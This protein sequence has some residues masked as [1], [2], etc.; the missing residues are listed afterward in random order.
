MG[1]SL[2]EVHNTRFGSLPGNIS[3]K[4]VRFLGRIS[5]DLQVDPLRF[6]PPKI[7]RMAEITR[8]SRESCDLMTEWSCKGEGEFNVCGRCQPCVLNDRLNQFTRWMQNTGSASQKRFLTG[9]LVRC[10]NLPMLENLRSV[11]K[12]TSGKDIN[13]RFRHQPNKTK[14]MS[15][16]SVKLHGMDMLE[17]WEWFRKSPEWT[18]SKYLLGVLSSCDT[19]LLHI[20]GNL[21]HSL[22]D[23][24]KHRFFQFK[25]A[26][27]NLKCFY[28]SVYTAT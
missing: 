22:I 21:V 12:V 23:W 13:P 26:G 19:H 2:T 5:V 28:R 10:Q 7:T 3:V 20:S 18:K 16:W 4:F 14:D 1:L 11:L 25:N 6:Q 24:E 15:S 17:T 9:I 27:E 8:V